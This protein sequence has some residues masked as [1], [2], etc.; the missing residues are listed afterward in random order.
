M[1]SSG[2]SLRSRL[3]PSLPGSLRASAKFF[4]SSGSSDIQFTGRGSDSKSALAPVVEQRLCTAESCFD[5]FEQISY[6]ELRASLF[7]GDSFDFGSPHTSDSQAS[8]NSSLLSR[9]RSTLS[10]LRK[11]SRRSLTKTRGA[12]ERNSTKQSISVPEETALIL[13]F[14]NRPSTET[15]RPDV[16]RTATTPVD[17]SSSVFY[18]RDPF[19]RVESPI[20]EHSGESALPLQ[21][22]TESDQADVSTS[23]RPFNQ[24]VFS[25]TS[26][27][28]IK[29]FTRTT[30]FSSRRSAPEV[31]RILQSESTN[32]KP[33]LLGA[34]NS[35]NTSSQVDIGFLPEL[36]FDQLDLSTLFPKDKPWRF[37][38]ISRR[39]R[40]S[41]CE[42]LQLSK[43]D[44]SDCIPHLQLVRY[45]RVDPH[46]LTAS[47]STSTIAGFSPAATPLSLH[48]PSWLSRNIRDFL[49]AEPDSP[50]LPIPPP[51]SPPL[52]ILPRSLLPASSSSEN[53]QWHY[54]SAESPDTPRSTSS[55]VTLCTTSRRVSSR[56]SSVYSSSRP[57]PRSS[58]RLSVIHCRR[59]FV[60]SRKSIQ[61]FIAYGS[62]A[63][64]T[65]EGDQVLAEI[66]QLAKD[67]S[68]DILLLSSDSRSTPLEQP[69]PP[70]ALFDTGT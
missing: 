46:D 58:N 27:K 17:D 44:V 38:R 52:P 21:I 19:R 54:E 41:F 40:D 62:I 2:K 49:T 59:S 61:S 29:T 13:A 66:Q 24:G 37:S 65:E 8:S 25:R 50:C 70:L 63:Y 11:V 14:P 6:D 68:L 55:S 1:P 47:P 16:S 4:S 12:L 3:A 56:R 32:H 51:A 57:R 23:T 9:S 26:L 7:L 28:R 69:L 22:V 67:P 34:S 42:F 33:H 5:D 18:D 64:S 36:S 35:P 10:R 60:D 30:F 39:D 31:C 53:T 20:E 15:P 43:P 48:S 45:E